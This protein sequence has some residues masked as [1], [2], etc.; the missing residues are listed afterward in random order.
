MESET[1]WV[2]AVAVVLILA[3]LY[4]YWMGTAGKQRSWSAGRLRQALLITLFIAV[5]GGWQLLDIHQVSK[6][7]RV[8]VFAAVYSYI[9]LTAFFAAAKSSGIPI[10][11]LLSSRGDLGTELKGKCDLSIR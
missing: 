1:F 4:G 10:R 7:V 5:F 6:W 9:L 3:P 11:K 8:A 2:I